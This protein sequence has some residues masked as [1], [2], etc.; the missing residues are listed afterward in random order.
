ML[1]LRKKVEPHPLLPRCDLCCTI[2][3]QAHHCC[4]S[5]RRSTHNF[6]ALGHVKMISPPVLPWMKQ[7][8]HCPSLG[9]PTIDVC[10]FIEI[11]GT[12]GQGPVFGAIIA[13]TGDRHDVFNL[14]WKIEHGFRCMA[15][16]T[17]MYGAKCHL[18]IVRI[19]RANLSVRAAVRAEDA[20]NSASTS[21]S[22]SICSSIGRVSPRSLTVRQRAI[23]TTSR[24][25]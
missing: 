19:H 25:C 9:V 21:V 14:H 16:F 20:R 3:P 18:G 17:T 15:I 22:S 6:S 12:T 4:P 13:A 1:H 24:S 7:T 5:K 23:N 11:A 10:G 2:H 8:D